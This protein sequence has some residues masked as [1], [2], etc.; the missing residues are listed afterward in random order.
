MQLLDILGPEVIQAFPER[1]DQLPDALWIGDDATHQ[2]ARALRELAPGTRAGLL[3]DERTYVAAGPMCEAPMRDAGFHLVN[4]LIPD[5]A[6]GH[7]PACDDRTHDVIAAQLPAVDLLVAIGSGVVNDLVKWVASDR[8]VPYGV[9]ATAASMNGY[10]SANVAAT[11]GGVKS[12]LHAS[13]PRVIAADP[14]VLASAPH[15]LTVAGLGDLIAKPVSTADWLMNHVLFDE[16]FE[17]ELVALV[18][19][20]E[21]RY[22]DH[23][24]A[25]AASTPS[26]VQALFETLVLSGCSMAL[27]GSSL[28]ASG[29]EHLISHTLD[30]M[31]QVD[32]VPHDLHGRQVGVATVFA[33]AL[34]QQILSLDTPSFNPSMPPLEPSVWGPAAVSVQSEYRAKVLR[35]SEACARLSRDGVWPRLRNGLIPLLRDPACIRDSLQRAGGAWCL[36]DIGCSRER[37]LTAALRCGSMR[38][39]FTSI[40]L[41]YATGVLPH[42]AASLVDRWLV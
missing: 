35:M 16:P 36:D 14:R 9:F 18:D 23:P 28:P 19:R 33:A 7:T 29:G 34:W 8:R 37:F 24:E 38:G 30:M 25:L 12:L 2:L 39:R 42:E 5:D 3:F 1:I 13:A 6:P 40:D 41:A 17:T 22:L 27:H 32:G 26:A 11:L 10:A 20:L 21:P 4:L 15:A 31:S